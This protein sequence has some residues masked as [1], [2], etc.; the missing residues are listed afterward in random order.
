MKDTP[1]LVINGPR[2]SGKSTLA[3]LCSPS[4]PDTRFVS[5][6]D[7]SVYTAAIDD[8]MGFIAGIK[9]SIVLDEIQRVPELFRAIKY[10]VD[11]DR[12]P[13]RFLLTGSADILLLPRISDSLA[14]RIEFFTLWPFSMGE[15][16]GQREDFADRVFRRESVDLAVPRHDRDTTLKA[17]LMGGFPEV[18]GRTSVIRRDAWFGAYITSILQRDVRDMSNIEQ[19]SAMPRLLSLIAARA[20]GL[21]NFSEMSRSLDLPQSTLKRYMTL[22]ERT[23]MVTA[24][25]PWHANLG[26]RLVKSPKLLLSDCGL[27]AHLLGIDEVEDVQ[28]RQLG[29]LAE[30]FVAMELIKQQGWSRRRFKLYHYRDQ[31]GREI[32]LVLER[33]DGSVVAIEIKASST[34]SPKDFQHIRCL[35]GLLGERFVRGIVLYMGESTIGFGEKLHA[36]PLN[37]LWQ[38]GNGESPATA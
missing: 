31:G 18:Q 20:T 26:K 36:L 2:Q 23:F 25:Q 9:G 30:N 13:G 15:L 27:M 29:A 32:D 8:P 14:G 1:V 22:L 37:A 34:V 19:L 12:Q 11:R 17:I 35:Q 4:G 16:Q 3:Q 24:L 6:D 21:V 28:P 7:A 33:P 5:L 10:A 38:G